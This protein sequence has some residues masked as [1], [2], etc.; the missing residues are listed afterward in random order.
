MSDPRTKGIKAAFYG[1]TIKWID[2]KSVNFWVFHFTD[3]T[4]A[5]IDTEAMGHGLYGPVVSSVPDFYKPSKPEKEACQH[6]NDD[7]C[8]PCGAVSREDCIC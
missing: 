7:G 5:G 3:G 4:T 8:D 6:C 1:K 2:T